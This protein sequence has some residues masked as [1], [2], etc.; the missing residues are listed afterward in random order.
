MA[1]SLDINS[2]TYAGEL[3][4]PYVRAAVLA[5]DSVANGY[6]TLKDGIKYKAVLKKL[7]GGTVVANSCDFSI[8]EGS[9]D[10]NEVIITPV[11]LSIME[12]ICKK[13]FRSDWEAMQTGAG[14]ANDQLPPNFE[15]F[16]IQYLAEIASA[17]AE[18]QMWQGKYNPATGA[19]TGTGVLTAYDGILA[20][21]VAGTP[22]DETTVAGAFTADNNGTTGV[23]THLNTL[24]SGCP[25][26]IAG[27]ANTVIFMSRKTLSLLQTAMAGV[28][29]FQANASDTTGYAGA[30]FSPTF[31]GQ[32]RP[33]TYL[34]YQI[35]VPNGFPND[36]LV[37]SQVSNFVFGTNLMADFNEV[38]IVDMTRTEA[39]DYIRM[40]MVFSGGTQVVSLTDVGVV[41]RSS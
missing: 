19:T 6:I 7:S 13:D 22:G 38:V 3:A 32:A 40:K 4:L 1:Q 30:G 29:V 28:A 20:H 41:R 31:V 11:E 5:A 16:L 18:K 2:S 37:I 12:Q 33:T 35:I 21:I 24:V 14:L 34:G 39:S 15:Q 27:D 36:T 8:T 17:N 23:L 10:L 9:L 26:A 25:D